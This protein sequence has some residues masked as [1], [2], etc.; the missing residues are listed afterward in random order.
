MVWLGVVGVC[1]RHVGVVALMKGLWPGVV[2]C[3]GWDGILWSVGMIGIVGSRGILLLVLL[4]RGGSRSHIRWGN[5]GSRLYTGARWYVGAVW[6]DVA[7]S[8][9]D[10]QALR[11]L[12]LVV[13]LLASWVSLLAGRVISST[14]SLLAGHCLLLPVL[15]L[16][17]AVGGDVPRLVAEVAYPILCRCRHEGMLD[18]FNG[19]FSRMWVL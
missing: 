2:C 9:V 17:W 3:E 4:M 1:G 14:S 13:A 19:V 18:H 16:G 6:N 11:R 5:R 7:P 15:P 8:G 12:S 10:E